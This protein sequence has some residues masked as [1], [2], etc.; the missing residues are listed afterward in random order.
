MATLEPEHLFVKQDTDGGVPHLRGSR[1]GW[2]TQPGLTAAGL[3]AGSVQG[4]GLTP[5]TWAPGKGS[6]GPLSPAAR[7]SR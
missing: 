1:L 2:G 7:P 6:S 3:I 5:V 4:A